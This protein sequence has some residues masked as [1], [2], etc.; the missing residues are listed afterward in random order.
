M[1]KVTSAV[2]PFLSRKIPFYPLFILNIIKMMLD[3]I[4][5]RKLQRILG[6]ECSETEDPSAT[7]VTAYQYI[8]SGSPLT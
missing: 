6:E 1:T 2:I 8:S 7:L 5:D 4:N 3:F